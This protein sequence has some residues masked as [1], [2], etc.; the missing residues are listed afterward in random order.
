[1]T[2]V[3]TMHLSREKHKKPQNT[4]SVSKILK[5][6]CAKPSATPSG[7]FKPSLAKIDPVVSEEIEDKHTDR[8]TSGVL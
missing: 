2:F 7:H 1:M 4:S 5:F 8:Q 3:S 6:F